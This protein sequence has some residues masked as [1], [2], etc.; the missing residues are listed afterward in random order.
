[1]VIVLG[2]RRVNRRIPG[3]TI[4]MV[5]SIVVASLPHLHLHDHG[6]RLV[7]DLAPIPMGL[8]PLT[9]PRLEYWSVLT[10]AAVACTV[11]SLVESSGSTWQPSL[12]VKG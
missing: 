6:L 2:L 3:S 8:P 1:M 7:A 9:I 10:P 12:R 11:L 5:I 4:A